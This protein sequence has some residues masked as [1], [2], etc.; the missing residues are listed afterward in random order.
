MI[1][2]AVNGRLGLLGGETDVDGVS[3]G[4]FGF[5]LDVSSSMS[6]SE[7]SPAGMSE[8]VETGLGLD[9]S[10]SGLEGIPSSP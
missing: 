3:R 4:G 10:A 7:S 5:E 2:S 6:T 8:T 9:T 1:W